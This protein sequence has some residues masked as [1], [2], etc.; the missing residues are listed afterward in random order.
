M[1]TDQTAPVPDDEPQAA[2][3]DPEPEPASESEPAPQPDFDENLPL[4]A[5]FAIAIFLTICAA[6]ILIAYTNGLA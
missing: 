6:L 5:L 2:P 3:V 4:I 1:D